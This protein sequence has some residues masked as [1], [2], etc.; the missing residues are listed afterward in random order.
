MKGIVL[1]LLEAP[2]RVMVNLRSD[3]S[4]SEYAHPLPS[5]RVSRV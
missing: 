2:A 1:D 3:R 5:A 4:G